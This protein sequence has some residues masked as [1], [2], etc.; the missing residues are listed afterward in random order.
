MNIGIDINFRGSF[1]IA[2][3]LNRL[4]NTCRCTARTGFSPSLPPHTHRGLTNTASHEDDPCD[5]VFRESQIPG[6]L[7]CRLPN[8]PG[9]HKKTPQG[10][11]LAEMR[12]IAFTPPGWSAPGSWEPDEALQTIGPAPLRAKPGE[13]LFQSFA[14]MI[15]F[16]SRELT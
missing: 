1:R 16:F 10:Q 13:S 4:K 6:H 2:P 7:K 15:W 14:T 9:R 11:A 12:S 8:Y 3:E 5:L